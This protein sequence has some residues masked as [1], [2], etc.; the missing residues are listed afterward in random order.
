MATKIAPFPH[1]YTVTLDDRMLRASPRSPIAA[2][3]PPQFGG[4]DDVWSPEELLVGAAL[5]CLWTTFE[6]YARRD[7]L[8]VTSWS[9]RGTAVLDRAPGVPV[10]TSLTLHVDLLV[11]AGDEERARR[12]LET[13][14]QRCII[15]NAL[16]VAVTLDAV[17]GAASASDPHAA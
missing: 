17:V 1:T 12:L 5:A 10:F 16:R 7:R 2:G 15:S 9:G 8:T 11:A 3:P 4:T 6:S 14:E 13:A